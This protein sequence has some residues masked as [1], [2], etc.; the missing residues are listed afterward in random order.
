MRNTLLMGLAIVLAAGTGKAFAQGAAEAALVH[1]MSTSAGTSLGTAL[2]RATGQL[3]GRTAEQIPHTVQKPGISGTKASGQKRAMPAKNQ[4]LA[5]SLGGSL[6]QSIQGG[7]TQSP[8]CRQKA[9]SVA[10]PSDGKQ[11][12]QTCAAEDT[13]EDAA[14]PAAITLPA[15][16]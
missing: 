16:R 3:A 15:T 2:G 1:S 13:H 7:E 5:S 12:P 14:H 10:K 8:A 6:I 11:P 9:T 4:A